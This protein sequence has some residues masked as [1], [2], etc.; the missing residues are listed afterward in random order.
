LTVSRL[1]CSEPRLYSLA[2][3]F[4]QASKKRMAPPAFP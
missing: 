3:V 1:M 2:Y 4:E